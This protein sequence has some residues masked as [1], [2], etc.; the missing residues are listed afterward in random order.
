MSSDIN[1]MNFNNVIDKKTVTDLFIEYTKNKP[2][3]KEPLVRHI[4]DV[5]NN[6]L[7]KRVSEKVL[8]IVKPFVKDL[9]NFLQTCTQSSCSLVTYHVLVHVMYTA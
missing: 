3:V 4:I 6:D 7:V 9:I 1:S 5:S 8:H 2:D